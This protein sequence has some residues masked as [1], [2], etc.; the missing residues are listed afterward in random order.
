MAIQST[1]LTSTSITQVFSATAQTAITTA[2]FCN[3][4]TVTDVTINVFAVPSGGAA[5]PQTQI[6]KEVPLTGGDTF[7]LDTERLVLEQNDSI[8]AQASTSNCVTVT[9]STLVTG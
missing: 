4:N 1:Y 5:L 7:V 3:V 6:M 2:I 9:V 8:W